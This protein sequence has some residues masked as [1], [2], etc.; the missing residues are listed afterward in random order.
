MK[1]NLKKDQL[2]DG[3]ISH[4]AIVSEPCGDEVVVVSAR[5]LVRSFKYNQWD[6]AKP[7]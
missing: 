3:S 4:V 6:A 5:N 2:I 1:P 7:L